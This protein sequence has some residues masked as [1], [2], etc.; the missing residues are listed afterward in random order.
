MIIDKEVLLEGALWGQGATTASPSYPTSASY[1]SDLTQ[2]GQDFDAARALLDE[3][4]YPEGSLDIV[5]KA[6]TNYP[7]HIESAQILVEWFR[8]AGVNMTIEQLTWADWLSQC[9]VD[10]IGRA[11]V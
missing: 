7:Y 3:A 4:G 8:A 5:F 1:N 2:R 10:K 6:T 9:W 11:H